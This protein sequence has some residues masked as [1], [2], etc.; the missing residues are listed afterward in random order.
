MKMQN[1]AVSGF[2]EASTRA[3]TTHVKSVS[4]ER[5]TEGCM[6]LTTFALTTEQICEDPK[7]GTGRRIADFA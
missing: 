7:L 3:R 4:L 1:L 6:R 5:V 2:N